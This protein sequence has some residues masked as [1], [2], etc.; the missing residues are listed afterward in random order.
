MQSP[1]ITTEWSMAK[2]TFDLV[3]PGEG[4]SQFEEMKPQGAH[5]LFGSPPC[6]KPII[7]N[8]SIYNL[9]DPHMHHA[10]QEKAGLMG[11]MLGSMAQAFLQ[12]PR[13]QLQLLPQPVLL[14]APQPALGHHHHDHHDRPPPPPYSEFDPHNNQSKKANK[15]WRGR[16]NG[17]DPS[18]SWGPTFVALASLASP[19]AK[20]FS[21]ALLDLG[22]LPFHLVFCP[23]CLLLL[24]MKRKERKETKVARNSLRRKLAPRARG[25][26]RGHKKLSARA[27]RG[28]KNA[29]IK[30]LI[31]L[32]CVMKKMECMEEKMKEMESIGA[33]PCS[34][35][36]P[37]KTSGEKEDR[38]SIK[39]CE[40]QMWKEDGKTSI[41][42]HSLCKNVLTDSSTSSTP[43]STTVKKTEEG[44]TSETK[45]PQSQHSVQELGV[46]SMET[47]M[48]KMNSKKLMGGVPRTPVGKMNSLMGRVEGVHKTP[49][50]NSTEEGS[51]IKTLAHEMKM[52]KE[53]GR[54]SLKTRLMKL[55]STTKWTS[56]TPTLLGLGGGAL[57]YG[58]G[59]G[60]IMELKNAMKK[61][62]GK[63]SIKDP[64]L[65]DGENPKTPL[66]SRALPFG[67]L[68]LA[69]DCNSHDHDRHVRFDGVC[70]GRVF[71]GS[72][73]D[74]LFKGHVAMI[75][76]E[77][78][79]EPLAIEFT[80]G[81]ACP[82]PVASPG[83]VCSMPRDNNRLAAP[84]PTGRGS[85]IG[86]IEE[87]EPEM[88][89]IEPPPH[90]HPDALPDYEEQFSEAIDEGPG[91]ENLSEE[92]A[93]TMDDD[94]YS[95][96]T[97]PVHP[98]ILRAQRHSEEMA[99]ALPI[100]RATTTRGVQDGLLDMLKRYDSLVD[101]TTQVQDAH[102][103]RLAELQ[104]GVFANCEYFMHQIRNI[105]AQHKSWH[106]WAQ[107]FATE[108]QKAI[109]LHEEKLQFLNECQAKLKGIEEWVDKV[110]DD[111][112]NLKGGGAETYR[113]VKE[114][115]RMIDQE[116][117]QRTYEQNDIYQKV[118][119][120]EANM[121]EGPV[122][123][124][125]VENSVKWLQSKTEEEFG[126]IHATMRENVEGQRKWSEQ[127]AQQCT[128]FQEGLKDLLSRVLVLEAAS[129]QDR[130]N[131]ATQLRAQQMEYQ[132]EIHR[133]QQQVGQLT[134]QGNRVEVAVSE[135][136]HAI[137]P[138]QVELAAHKMA[139]EK[140]FALQLQATHAQRQVPHPP[141]VQN[142]VPSPP[143]QPPQEEGATSSAASHPQQP[144][145]QVSDARPQI[146]RATKG[147]RGKGTRSENPFE[148]R[149]Q[150]SDLEWPHAPKSIP[151]PEAKTSRASVNVSTNVEVLGERK[152]KIN[153]EVDDPFALIPLP[154]FSVKL[155]PVPS[156]KDTQKEAEAAM[157]ALSL[158]HFPVNT[159]RSVMPHQIEPHVR[160][161]METQATL[162]E[163]KPA[164]KKTMRGDTEVERVVVEKS[165]VQT[166]V[167]QKPV[168]D[169]PPASKRKGGKVVVAK[170]MS[171][172]ADWSEGSST[173]EAYEAPPPARLSQ[174]TSSMPRLQ[175]AGPVVQKGTLAVSVPRPL[176]KK[177]GKEADNQPKV[178]STSQS[179]PP[180][181]KGPK[182]TVKAGL[183]TLSQVGMVKGHI[184]MV[185]G[186]EESEGEVE[187]AWEPVP[188]RNGRRPG[189][190]NADPL[191]ATLGAFL[192]P[193]M[194]Q[195]QPPPVFSGKPQ[196]WLAYRRLMEQW[197]NTMDPNH[198]AHDAL[199]FQQLRKTLDRTSRLE[200]DAAMTTE[201]SLSFWDY[202]EELK[203]KFEDELEFFT[204]QAWSRVRL[205][206]DQGELTCEAWR[207]YQAKYTKT[208]MQVLDKTPQEEREKIFQQIP[209]EWRQKVIT[210]ESRRRG[211]QLWV[212][213]HHP[214]L[215]LEDVQY[216]VQISCEESEEVMLYRTELVG[217]FDVQCPDAT[218][219]KKLKAADGSRLSG[220]TIRVT[221]KKLKMS[222]K[223]IFEF[224]MQR[225]KDF[226]EG[227]HQE[228]YAYPPSQ[229]YPHAGRSLQRQHEY[230]RDH[231]Q[232]R[233]V[234]SSRQSK[235]RSYHSS[236]SSEGGHSRVHR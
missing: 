195:H 98:S 16:Q 1:P 71:S 208:G 78:E 229:R 158:E 95:N 44:K 144:P 109:T 154:S 97:I 74:M 180:P 164:L 179:N 201:P 102:E 172:V 94:V 219:H 86:Q 188:Q 127:L 76:S 9:N 181:K 226:E 62:D 83:Q 212:R 211:K 182:I 189:P 48:Q 145:P 65:W 111:R 178:Q 132:S 54:T 150:A 117:Q 200:L 186:E 103:Q 225:L 142:L 121:K 46:S 141:Q 40:S 191:A 80:Q 207:A 30:G 99:P 56:S 140:M 159:L 50:T 104:Q 146:P 81:V 213:V 232:V 19:A 173:E 53:E 75:T 35:S 116:R 218:V 93:Q 176:P 128:Y 204:R 8:M 70:N 64:M 196:G 118:L 10:I 60:S 42:T 77:G 43:L 138:L 210:E 108:S 100:Q 66:H 14:P 67:Q 143:F 90:L 167:M 41:K 63:T 4:C 126:K 88:L 131:V 130:Q 27:K 190:A 231:S 148:E 21:Y 55:S 61:E 197:L 170:E 162:P 72:S 203:D 184:M 169:Q 69:F 119:E 123:L 166:L 24:G 122:D 205:E 92:G 18:W 155:S 199:L 52:E 139:R 2:A 6:T 183:A 147:G 59:G 37:S 217:T 91:P 13:H 193:L 153:E 230:G 5:S 234:S 20:A 84:I 49:R 96:A 79:G 157:Q 135:C 45:K 17:Q 124:T 113:L 175:P 15:N 216:L 51:S 165:V 106:Q 136:T 171:P 134:T 228:G 87:D 89:E 174:P 233:G 34:G 221:N 107:S 11:T 161:T 168:M 105:D 114:C 57:H 160:V 32:R 36:G 192:N 12:Q 33:C 120:V 202:W 47:P 215:T 194:L 163:K 149:A 137:T 209:N 85:G 222:T 110:N 29:S 125:E 177:L 152:F 115:L 38:S 3:W 22:A 101:K 129:V 133:L 224:V 68:G 223:E 58:A 236:S 73:S 25:I 31:L 151:A 28:K 7:N 198:T 23:L 214:E 187:G 185:R 227:R 220:H 82:P 206:L 235:R 156:W 39:T 26:K 112:R